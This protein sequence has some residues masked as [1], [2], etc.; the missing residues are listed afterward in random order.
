MSRYRYGCGCARCR[1]R[2]LLGPILL[3]TIGVMFLLDQWNYV[4]FWRMSPVILIV[5]GLVK[6]WQSGM[7]REGHD[8]GMLPPSTPAPPVD[9]STTGQ[10]HN[11]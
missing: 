6:V 2:G 8:S 10:V 4:D 3:V 11:G 9:S 7:S 5:I 1:S